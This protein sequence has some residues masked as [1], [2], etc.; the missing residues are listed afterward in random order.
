[1]KWKR[2]NPGD[3]RI[4]RKFCWIPEYSWYE[5]VWLEKAWVVERY[6]EHGFQTI[7][8]FFSWE[9]ANHYANWMHEDKE[10]EQM[11]VRYLAMMRE[12]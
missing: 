1:M 11:K 5:T 10:I 3:V 2:Y 8:V 12:S 4:R 7:G 9:D 6:G